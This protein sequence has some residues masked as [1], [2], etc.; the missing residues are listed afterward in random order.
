M[1]SPDEKMENSFH[2]LH[3]LTNQIQK[4]FFLADTFL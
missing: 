3:F 2:K 1:V 4:Q